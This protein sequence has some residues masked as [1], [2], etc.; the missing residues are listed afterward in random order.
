MTTCIIAEKP[1]VA[2]DIARIVGAKN[3]ENGFLEGNGYIVT[4]AMGH[5]I[6][7]AMPQTYG[8]SSYNKDDLPITPNPFKLVV[9][10]VRKDKEYHDDPAALKQLKVIRECF[11]KADIIIVG[12]DAGREG[13]LIFRWIYNYLNC[14]KPFKRLWISS[15]TDKAI[16]EGL[17][18]LKNGAD[19][20]NLYNSAQ[21]RSQ[22]DWLVGINASRALSIA[23]RGA[24][25]LGRVQTPTLAMVC[26]RFIENKEFKSVPYWKVNA[27]LSKDG[28]LIKAIGTTSFEDEA[29]CRSAL[30]K[31]RETSSLTVT[32]VIRKTGHTQ[33]PLLYD[34]TTLQKEA[35]RQHGFSA[36]KTLSI[37]QSLYEKKVTTYPRTGSRYIS[38]DIFDE[39]PTLLQA[40]GKSIPTPF[41][42]NSVNNDKVTDHHAIIPTGETSSLNSDESIIYQ[43]ILSRFLEAFSQ[44]SQEERMQ[45]IF[46]DG[47]NTYSWKACHQLSQGW[48]AISQYKGKDISQK[49]EETEEE[50]NMLPD[51]K[52]GEN[53]SI[54][55]SDITQHKTKPKALYTE[56][57]LLAAMENAGKD[58]EDSD[59]RKA[60]AQCGIGTPATRAN[61]IETLILRDYIQR[62]KKNIIPTDKGLLVY[63]IV[64][65]KKIANVD[66]TGAW[67]VA[68]EAIECGKMQQSSFT[69]SINKYTEQICSELI[70]LAEEKRVIRH[71]IVQ[72]AAM[73]V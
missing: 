47:N 63:N 44:S 48:K 50:L 66:M 34:L 11:N 43:M 25:S 69:D 57:T 31:L 33:P 18:N 73:K 7:L 65:D 62:E 70:A 52:E 4:W 2:R 28:I 46:T 72:N 71:I 42:K 30:S 29:L 15:L 58:I 14:N 59:Q 53:Y 3:K 20:N 17:D 68:L 67:E 23:R 32:S 45:V 54:T 26:K 49:N 12:T 9:R 16:R 22:A 38:E 39:I 10:Q 6:A 41:N 40:L 55:D 60:I 5:L 27:S 8:F 1:S 51:I 19:Y 24:Y 61:I 56:A 21:A 37:A 35:N 64:K 13:E 36:D